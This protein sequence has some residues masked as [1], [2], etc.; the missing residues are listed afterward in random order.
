MVNVR[1]ETIAKEVVVAI[2][3]KYNMTGD[4]VERAG[5]IGEA[6]GKMNA[7]VVNAVEKASP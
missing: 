2:I 1:H 4:I 7:A 3:S 6:A 5:E